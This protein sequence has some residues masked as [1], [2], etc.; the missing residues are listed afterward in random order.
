MLISTIHYFF[1]HANIW[2]SLNNNVQNI[3]YVSS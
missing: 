3:I 1:I 2:T